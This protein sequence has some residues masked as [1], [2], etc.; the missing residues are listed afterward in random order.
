[1]L[2]IERLA[3]SY[4][5][6]NGAA[7]ACALAEVSF[8]VPR[9][10]FVSLLGPSGCGK[11]TL[12]Q[13]V[14]GLLA[15]SHG[16]VLLD[17]RE[18]TGPP[19][20]MALIFQNAS[21]SLFPW[22]TVAGNIRFVLRRKPGS[23]KDKEAVAAKALAD[24][25][26]AAFAGHYPWQ[27]SGGMQQRAALARGLAYGADV[28]LLDEPFASVDAQT[29]EELEDLL[30]GVAASQ[31]KTVLFVTHDIDEAVYLSDAVT[32]LTPAPARVAAVIPVD[33]PRPRDQ[34][35]ARED[36][37][38]LDARKTIHALLRH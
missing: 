5:G 10:G 9:G 6:H 30:A 31:A 21:A 23:K 32:V 13:C 22:M 38:F 2:R 3:K 25:G 7:S 35:A 36:R 37:R 20:E 19:P 15:P 18:V 4:A 24:V 27:L 26:L 1:M 16:R 8:S 29:R 17:D 33:L 34:V 12:L 28:L 14:C 11:S